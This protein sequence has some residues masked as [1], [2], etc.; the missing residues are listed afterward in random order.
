MLAGLAVATVAIA[1]TLYRLLN[2]GL[3]PA[4][5]IDL[6]VYMQG[7]GAIR[8][9]STLY[10]PGFGAGAHAIHLPFTYPPF[11]A[12]VL[13]PASYIPLG[14]LDWIWVAALVTLLGGC[15]AI[16]FRPLIA[17]L[18][19]HIGSGLAVVMVTSLT[20]L[21]RPA[22]DNL[23]FGQV[24]VALMAAC[25]FACASR[26]SR[27]GRAV[28]V[29]L[30]AAIKVVPG[31]FIVYLVLTKR[32]RMAAAA[33]GTW[34]VATGLGFALRPGA[35]VAYY[36]H[37]LWKPGRPGPTVSY[38]NQSAWGIVER[39]D[40]GSLKLPI[41][42]LVVGVL[43]LVGLR[44][45]RRSWV[46]GDALVAAVMVGLVSVLASPISWI[47]ETIWLV[48]SL[49][50]VLGD[51]RHRNRL[52]VALVIAGVMLASF[53]YLG[54]L[55]LDPSQWYSQILIDTYGLIAAGLVL[56]GFPP[57][58]GHLQWGARRP[59]G[60]WVHPVVGLAQPRPLKRQAE[61]A[62]SWPDP[63][64]G[65]SAISA[66]RRGQHASTAAIIAASTA[67]VGAVG[68]GGRVGGAGSPHTAALA[69]SGMLACLRWG[70]S[71]RLDPSMARLRIS[72]RR[73]SA[74]S[75]TSSR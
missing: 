29:G 60:R 26:R 14:L 72:T 40:P 22:F 31:I 54:G 53:P 63:R 8:A 62:P 70:S 9:G 58:P 23:S 65:S 4:G 1:I 17:R 25:I 50:L 32:W 44:R 43:G 61:P 56:A 66:V 68:G 41:V 47:H 73:V 5:P 30:A 3:G 75:I 35:S 11:A 49:G 16:C 12:M 19:S 51:A 69:H 55:A 42:A 34:A 67:G 15:V 48:P 45:A 33:L 18:R 7:A 59:V 24:D 52:G 20:L 57:W 71:L 2:H 39:L 36:G 13:V 21:A 38:L 27:S 74:G 6:R 28:L 46:Q 37:L 64:A 10:T